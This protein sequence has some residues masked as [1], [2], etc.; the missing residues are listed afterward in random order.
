MRRKALLPFVAFDPG[1]LG[2]AAAFE[3]IVEHGAPALGHDHDGTSLYA[4]F[5]FRETIGL[6]RWGTPRD[7]DERWFRV[8]TCAAHLAARALGEQEVVLQYTLVTLLTD[9]LVLDADG[10][11]DAPL[12]LLF[13]VFGEAREGVL[14]GE[15]DPLERDADEAFCLLAQLLVRSDVALL[16]ALNARLVEVDASAREYY[17]PGTHEPNPR[18]VSDD[19]FVWGLTTFDQLHARWSALVVE[20]FPSSSAALEATRAKLIDGRAR[21]RASGTP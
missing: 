10:A 9:A 7:L 6:T 17:L 11:P 14:R 12:E 8:L 18:F 20:R 1:A 13:D 15:G 3:A 4:S 16:D 2:Y 5:D 21:P 19:A